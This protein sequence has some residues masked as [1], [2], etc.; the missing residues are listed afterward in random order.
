TCDIRWR[1]FDVA[2]GPLFAVAQPVEVVPGEMAISDDMN[3]YQKSFAQGHNA[4]R[5][6]ML[7]H[8]ENERDMVERVSQS[9]RLPDNSFTNDDLEMMAHGDNPQS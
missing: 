5:A 3:L 9:Y 8:S 4:C 7:N 2:P 1:R 6:A